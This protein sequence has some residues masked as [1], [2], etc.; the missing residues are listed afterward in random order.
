M[1]RLKPQLTK[2]EVGEVVKRLQALGAVKM[3]VPK[4]VDPMR[5]RPDRKG[6]RG[7]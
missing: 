4:G 1:Q 3:P 5:V 2:A 6:M 7:R